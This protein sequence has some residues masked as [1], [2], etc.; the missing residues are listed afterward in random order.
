M[1]LE[2]V[3]EVRQS[4][5]R[6]EKM[7][8]VLDRIPAVW[9]KYLPDPGW[10]N[11]ILT[12]DKILADIDPEYEIYQV[13]E[14]FGTLRFYAQCNNPDQDQN[15]L[16]HILIGSFESVSKYVCESCGSTDKVYARTA[17]WV[18]TLCEQCAK[19]QGKWQPKK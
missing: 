4:E 13:K 17:G 7:K 6:L 3:H 11:L 14:K 16:G 15:N 5:E 9:G 2:Q 8:P 12:L 1:K 10:D 19:D 18:K